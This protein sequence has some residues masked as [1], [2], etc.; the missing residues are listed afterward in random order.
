MTTV[1][2]EHVAT[3]GGFGGELAAVLLHAFFHPSRS[4]PRNARITLSSITVNLGQRIGSRQLGSEE[5][6]ELCTVWVERDM[7]G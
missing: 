6:N 2:S 3:Q 5:K 1:F 4:E 7:A